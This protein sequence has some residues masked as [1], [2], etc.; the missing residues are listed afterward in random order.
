MIMTG[1]KN[2]E[3][4]YYSDCNKKV[5]MDCC[6]LLLLASVT[7]FSILAVTGLPTCPTESFIEE[8]EEA[9]EAVQASVRNVFAKVLND[10]TIANDSLSSEEVYEHI[11]TSVGLSATPSGF[12]QFQ[13]AV[14]EVVVA[15][16]DACSKIDESRIT[17]EYI[18]ELT[19]RF[20]ALTDAN[21]IS[22][23]REVYGK[24]LCIQD[25][26]SPS[27][28]SRKRRQGDPSD[29]LDKFFNSLDGKRKA[30]IFGIGILNEVPPT[31]AFVVDDTG[32]IGTE[33]SFVQKFIRSFI[34]TE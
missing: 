3:I 12:V 10:S 20:I 19:K 18:S 21:N 11:T 1:Y 22:L 5:I 13:E 4:H 7:V 2:H 23:A 34:K 16:L 25:L 31:L 14:S 27:N 32:S 30:T 8:R 28:K 24:L 29:Q 17:T 9:V 6:N 15:K 33:I 26:L